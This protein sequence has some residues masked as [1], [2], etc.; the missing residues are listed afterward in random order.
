M[1]RRVQWALAPAVRA[2]VSRPA[3]RRLAGDLRTLLRRVG[4]P[5][6]TVEL[7]VCDDVQMS[8]LHERHFGYAKPTDVLSFPADD[9]PAFEETGALAP[10]PGQIVVNADAVARQAGAGGWSA[11]ARSL[12][13]HAVAHLVGHDHGTPSQAR[14]MLRTERRLGRVLRVAVCRPYGGR[15]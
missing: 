8:A 14:A 13:I 12:C 4:H 11:E 6:A 3:V 15:G 5:D 7:W 1:T 9:G 2:R 10:A